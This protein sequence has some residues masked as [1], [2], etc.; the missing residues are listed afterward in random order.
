MGRT[1]STDRRQETH[2]AYRLETI[3]GRDHLVHSIKTDITELGGNVWTG[4]NWLMTRTSG[5]NTVNATSA[6]IRLKT[7]LLPGRLSACEAGLY[8]MQ[9]MRYP[10]YYLRTSNSLP[11]QNGVPL[12]GSLMHKA[13][14]VTGALK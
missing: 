4:F 5:V 12:L 2:V 1:H 9:L 14:F 3:N 11:V 6:S 7:S 8:S 10:K 13:N